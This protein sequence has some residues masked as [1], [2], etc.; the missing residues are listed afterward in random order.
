MKSTV[1]CHNKP[2][3]EEYTKYHKPINLGRNVQRNAIGKGDMWILK[4]SPTEKRPLELNFLKVISSSDTKW[5]WS[6]NKTSERK[7]AARQNK[8]LWVFLVSRNKG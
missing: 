5:K 2:P 8:G 4:H 6:T 3:W 1:M 7:Q